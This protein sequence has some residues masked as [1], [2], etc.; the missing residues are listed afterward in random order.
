VEGTVTNVF[1]RLGGR[2]CT[3]PLAS[4]C[5]PGIVRGALLA[6]RPLVGSTGRPLEI[7]E[8]VLG[9]EELREAEEILLTNSLQRVVGV[10]ELRGAGS[11]RSLPGA[12]GPTARAAAERV[13]A[14]EAAGSGPVSSGPPGC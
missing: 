11:T 2:L 9:P 13:L 8:A 6:S 12:S 14:L 4:G 7:V 3:P 10:A 1:A 5:L